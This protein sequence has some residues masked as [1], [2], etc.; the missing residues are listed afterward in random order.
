MVMCGFEG[1]S[2]PAQSFIELMNQYHVGNIIL[3]G[4]N[5]RDFQQT[6]SLIQMLKQESDSKIPLSFAIDVE[7]GSVLR[8]SWDPSLSS[9]QTLA[10]HKT[11]EDTYQQYLRIGK[12]LFE[13]GITIDL[14]PVLDIA[15]QPSKSFLGKRMF[16][17]D[18]EITVPHAKAAIRGLQDGGLRSFGK[19]FPGHGNTAT[20]SHH[21]LPVLNATLEDWSD[22]ELTMFQAAVDEQIDGI[23]VGH[24]SYPNIDPDHISSVSSIFITDLLRK[25]MGFSGV[26]MSDD[27]RMQAI[28]STVGVG[29]GAISFVEA[30]GDMILIGRY[31]DKQT[32]V[33]EALY[34]ALDSGRL[35]RSRL[36]ESVYRILIMK[37][38]EP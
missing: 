13:I 37:G 26:I 36:E 21:S 3:F 25:K 19:H 7:G 27:M 33:F 38:F 14:A 30:G 6:A 10:K 31:A 17:S 16:G 35:S 24:L 8:F 20:D 29:E 11:P 4:W 12:Q 9:A 18:P 34:D 32:A 1:A 5:T 2:A 22:Y 23:L 28:A 15:R